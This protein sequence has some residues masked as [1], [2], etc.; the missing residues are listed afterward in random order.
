MYVYFWFERQYAL[1]IGDNKLHKVEQYR[2]RNV[3][4]DISSQSFFSELLLT[5]NDNKKETQLKVV[6][7][8]QEKAFDIDRRLYF[9][10]TY[11]Y[12]PS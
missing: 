10:T 12:L 9:N 6:Q 3:G 1:Y 11:M 2:Q 7:L 8:V 5:Y 4:V